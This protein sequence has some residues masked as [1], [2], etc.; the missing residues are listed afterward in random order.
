M[1]ARSLSQKQINYIQ[2]KRAMIKDLAL[3]IFDS[4]TGG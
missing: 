3:L 1:L 4:Q 2:M